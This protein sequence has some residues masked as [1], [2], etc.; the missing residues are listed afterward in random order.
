VSDSVSKINK[1]VIDA[2]KHTYIFIIHVKMCTKTGTRGWG[3]RGEGA[4]RKNTDFSIFTKDF[5]QLLQEFYLKMSRG[6][7]P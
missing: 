7:N 4:E 1:K 6:Y 5:H 3:G 2:I